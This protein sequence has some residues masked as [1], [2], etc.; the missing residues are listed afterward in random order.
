MS[1]EET[2]NVFIEKARKVLGE[3][4]RVSMGTS[5]ALAA[6]VELYNPA[7]VDTLRDAIEVLEEGYQMADDGL[8]ERESVRV[9][10]MIRA[11]ALTLPT[12]PNLHVL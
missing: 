11:L 4:E 7:R 3:E 9:A 8:I 12:R 6:L 5:S 1:D 10:A 2:L